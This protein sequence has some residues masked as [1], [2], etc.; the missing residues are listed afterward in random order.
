M[1]THFEMPEWA[2]DF[3]WGTSNDCWWVLIGITNTWALQKHICVYP[4]TFIKH[5]TVRESYSN[6]GEIQNP[7]NSY[8]YEFTGEFSMI[9]IWCELT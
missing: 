6:R 7:T 1:E 9:Q 2:E 5:Y 8:Q 4:P 3:T